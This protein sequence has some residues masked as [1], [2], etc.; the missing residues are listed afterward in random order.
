M[1]TPILM[2]LLVT[3]FALPAG[4][5]SHPVQSAAHGAATAGNSVVQG[6]GK[7]GQG[8]VGG[9]VTAARGVRRGAVCVFTLGSRCKS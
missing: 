2:A 3:A 8:I 4:A 7:A 6:A 9:T 1:R 5:A